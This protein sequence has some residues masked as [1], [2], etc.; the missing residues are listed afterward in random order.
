[1]LSVALK[2]EFDTSG[3]P[4]ANTHRKNKI[5]TVQI[6]IFV[7][8]AFYCRPIGMH[9]KTTWQQRLSKG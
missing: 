1:M 4:Y 2:C 8:I 9:T 7:T 3:R 6:S 5:V